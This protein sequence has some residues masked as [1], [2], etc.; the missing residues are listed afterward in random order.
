MEIRDYNNLYPGQ[1]FPDMLTPIEKNR[2]KSKLLI[3]HAFPDT[4]G[5][6]SNNLE[7]TSN[8]YS[9]RKPNTPTNNSENTLHSRKALRRFNSITLNTRLQAEIP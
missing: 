7:N 3:F 5:A 4:I 1:D 8:S 9:L 2:E 6:E